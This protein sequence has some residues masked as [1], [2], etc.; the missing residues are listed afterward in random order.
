M[1]CTSLRNQLKCPFP[2]HRTQPLFIFV[3]SRSQVYMHPNL[4]QPSPMVLS[5]GAPLKGP[6]S[7]FPAMQASDLVKPQSGSHYQPMNGS[8]PMVY[9]G[10]MNQGAGMGS[11]QLMDS[12]LIQVNGAHVHTRI[13]WWINHLPENV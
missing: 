5:G 8:Q 12:Q 3:F 6:Y 13:R 2:H 9:D 1:L 4:S 10:Q 11:S 7:A